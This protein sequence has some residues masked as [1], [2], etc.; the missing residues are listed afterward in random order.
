MW[1]PLSVPPALRLLALFVN[2]EILVLIIVI[3]SIEIS[4]VK[5]KGI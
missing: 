5:E 1:G 3:P 4:F 2:K